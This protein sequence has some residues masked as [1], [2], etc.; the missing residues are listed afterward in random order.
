[1][2]VPYSGVG[3]H[4]LVVLGEDMSGMKKLEFMGLNGLLITP[5]TY[6]IAVATSKGAILQ[7]YLKI[8]RFGYI[9]WVCWGVGTVIT[10][11]AMAVVFVSIFQ[12]NPISSLWKDINHT[13]CINTQLFFGYASV[14]NVITDVI[15]LITPM[16]EI[17]RLNT[18]KKMKL[19]VSITLLTASV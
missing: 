17:W 7:L 14:P 16:P 13:N 6:S 2:A 15:M 3:R 19:G 5:I 9:R 8:F 4:T 11:H 10:L 18:S 12:C 1:M